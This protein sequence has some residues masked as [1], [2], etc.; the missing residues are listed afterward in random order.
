[1]WGRDAQGIVRMVFD[2]SGALG[3]FRSPGWKGDTLVFEGE[4]TSNGRKHPLR[5]TITRVG[6]NEFRA[7]WEAQRDGAWKPYSVER[8]TRQ[9]T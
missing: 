8:L 4:V 3:A 9:R 6:P 2:G 7:V 1:M 5:Q